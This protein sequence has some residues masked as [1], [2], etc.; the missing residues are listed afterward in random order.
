MP[1]N[2]M[3]MY[4]PNMPMNPYTNMGVYPNMFINNIGW[5]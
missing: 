4:N 2:L 1:E 3:N 5:H